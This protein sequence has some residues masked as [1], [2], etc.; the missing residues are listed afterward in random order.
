MSLWGHSHSSHH[1]QLSAQSA[2]L[3]CQCYQATQRC[4][5]RIRVAGPT[6]ATTR[7]FCFMHV[8]LAVYAY[9]Y[10]VHAWCPEALDPLELELTD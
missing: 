2:S 10:H 7:F 9:I 3:V 1:K 4:L 5:C 6:T 8:Y